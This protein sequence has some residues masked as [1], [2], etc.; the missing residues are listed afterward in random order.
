MKIRVFLLAMLIS[1]MAQCSETL[2]DDENGNDNNGLKLILSH[3]S[4]QASSS[5]TDAAA[6]GMNGAWN[7]RNRSLSPTTEQREAEAFGQKALQCA[8]HF[9]Q[10]ESEVAHYS[11]QSVVLSA[12][13]LA[14]AAALIAQKNRITQ[15]RSLGGTVAIFTAGTI[16]CAGFL[17]IWEGDRIQSILGLEK[18]LKKLKKEL[19]TMEKEVRE[20]K[21][22]NGELL[23]KMNGIELLSN[24]VREGLESVKMVSG[25]NA[26]L[27]HISLQLIKGYKELDARMREMAL[28]LPKDKREQFLKPMPEVK[29]DI[30][31]SRPSDLIPQKERLELERK[32]ALKE[33]NQQFKFARWKRV[34][35]FFDIPQTIRSEKYAHLMKI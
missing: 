20:C 24:E 11:T 30:D 19:I 33:Y 34:E 17:A 16:A 15:T 10:M 28:L 25:D 26:Q 23:E 27:A 31:M 14:G 5:T 7:Q 2:S 3:P 6:S 12:T 13:S 21:E 4:S 9:E 35:S 29:D 8:R 32:I 22:V 1:T 18:D